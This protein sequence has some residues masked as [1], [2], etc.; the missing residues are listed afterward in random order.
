MKK[1]ENDFVEHEFLL[2]GYKTLE[3]YQKNSVPILCERIS[4][5]LWTRISYS[6]LY[7]DKGTSFWGLNRED[8]FYHNIPILLKNVNSTSQYIEHKVITKSKRK[9]VLVKFKCS[10]GNIFEKLLDD[11]VNDKYICC[12]DCANKHR[13]KNHRI[14]K[15]SLFGYIESKGYTVLDKDRGYTT[16]EYIEVI[17]EEGYIGFVTSS[18][19][20]SGRR[21]SKFDIRSNKKNYIY[22]VNHYI[23]INGLNLK[24]V[25]FSSK[26]YTRQ[27]LTFI[28]SCGNT[29]E[30]SIAS[31]QNGKI[32][33]CKC[34]NKIS[35]L[36]L[37]FENML[38]CENI[39]YIYQY[40]LNQCRDTL[41]LPFDFYIKNYDVLVEIDGEGHY[42]PCNFNQ[43]SN[44]EALKSFNII[45]K[46][47]KIKDDYCE[48]NGI[49]LIRIPYYM[50][51]KNKDY[52]NFFL[53]TLRSNEP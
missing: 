47:D 35:S 31:F 53:N 46:H 51:N 14:K 20:H 33:C 4:D 23:N 18:G 6:N 5:G 15:S 32:R 10:C 42:H 30:T 38:K 43:I 24:C 45:K 3:T 9:R 2:K 21:M 34:S 22:N 7:C 40:S 39:Q 11:V 48:A 50:F 1:L 12:K 52:K 44:E 49:K 13:G 37:E 19:L 28:C 17:D 25:G 26:D 27:G 36:E 8:L 16:Q 41:P 29:F